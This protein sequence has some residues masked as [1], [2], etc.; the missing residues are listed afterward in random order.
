VLAMIVR[1]GLTLTI[2]GLAVGAAISTGMT[3]L[4][5]GMLY[6]I[7][8]TDLTTFATTAALLLLVSGVASIVPAYRAAR[9]DPIRTLR[10]Q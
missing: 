1:R 4:L 9:L 8:P 6:G 7:R 3:R 5:T 10:E 2:I